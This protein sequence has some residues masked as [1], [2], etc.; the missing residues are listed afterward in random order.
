MTPTLDDD[1]ALIGS[2]LERFVQTRPDVQAQAAR[3]KYSAQSMIVFFLVMQF[4]RITAFK[5]QRRWLATHPQQ[6]RRIGFQALPHRTTLSRRY[7][8][9]ACLVEGLVAFVGEYVADLDEAFANTL[10]VE[11]KSLFKTAG[12]VWH[13]ADRRVGR[14]PPKLR[15]IDTDATWSKSGY[16]G[17][18]YGYGLHITCTTHAFPKLARVATAAVAESQVLDAK[19]AT[20]IKNLRPHALAA[21]N[22]YGR[23]TRIRRW[24]KAG[25]SLVCP[26]HRW[27]RGRYA[28][29]YHRFLKRPR[30]QQLLKQRKPSVEPLFDLLAKLIG[31]TGYQKQLL[32]QRLLHARSA[33]LLGTLSLQVAM[34]INSM[35]GR[36]FREIALMQAAF[37]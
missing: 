17:W 32:V 18:V 3:C 36:P 4:R 23:A 11:D 28:Q 5:A 9:V 20:I 19:E 22:R 12:P 31:A 33:L 35:W 21:D 25:I 10:L 15:R 14:I 37:S 27:T 8:Q 7:K 1:T 26:A 24:A 6:R 30:A 13:Q 29:S 16:Q 2:L 34:I